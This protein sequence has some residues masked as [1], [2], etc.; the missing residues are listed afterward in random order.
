M[1]GRFRTANKQA[2]LHLLNYYLVILLLLWTAFRKKS[3][4]HVGYLMYGIE[5]FGF[6]QNDITL[7]IHRQVYNYV[8]ER[9]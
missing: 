7:Y 9:E 8:M 5:W 1:L 2:L 6:Q 4:L 3:S